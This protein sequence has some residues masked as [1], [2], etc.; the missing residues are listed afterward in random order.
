MFPL[1]AGDQAF[2]LLPVLGPIGLFQLFS[3]GSQ[4]IRAE[5]GAR[6]FQDVGQPA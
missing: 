1:D 4:P 5:G 3:K 6:R 2:D